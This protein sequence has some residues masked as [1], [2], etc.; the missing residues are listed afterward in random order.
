MVTGVT[1]LSIE[2][3]FIVLALIVLP[4]GARDEP[5]RHSFAHALRQTWLH[6]VHALPTVF[7]GGLL[8]V[9]WARAERAFRTHNPG[10][11]A[12]QLAYLP[13]PTPPANAKPDSQE[14]K[15]YQAALTVHQTEI[16]NYYK[17]YNERHRAWQRARPFFL[18]FGPGIM[19]STCVALAVWILVSLLRGVGAVRPL[20]ARARPPTCEICGYNLTTMAMTG[21][22]PECGTPV[23]ES[24]GPE[25]R[26]GTAWE[27]RR[28]RGRW[29]TYLETSREALLEP[30]RLGQRIR[31]LAFGSDHY[32]LLWF[33]LVIVGF[34][35][36][37]TTSYLMYRDLRGND[38]RSWSEQVPVA[39]P[40]FS[41]FLALCT[42]AVVSLWIL[43]VALNY[44]WKVK[45]NL[46]GVVGRI[47]ACQSLYLVFWAL[48]TAAFSVAL[49]IADEQRLFRRR[50][51]LWRQDDE[52]II[53]LLAASQNLLLAGG[54]L[55]LIWRGTS[56]ARYANR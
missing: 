22:C 34:I 18:R 20:P 48:I 40:F 3:G 54:Y 25:A 27:Q 16:Q 39:L 12:Q 26:P 44:L 15:D 45:R 21:R 23:A 31:A 38:F 52:L 28:E 46:A 1:V 10:P 37:V 9:A 2:I 32:R 24:L 53:F 41:S 35:T 50:G 5:L 47:A 55:I 33:H 6:S 4:F 8:I 36:A 13:P 7:L 49:F 19:M 42:L 51:Y 14:W 43:I 11:W 56:A 30:K 17:R 29:R